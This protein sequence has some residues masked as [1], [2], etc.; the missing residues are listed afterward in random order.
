MS[1]LNHLI[2]HNYHRNNKSQHVNRQ[3]KAANSAANSA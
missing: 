2:S 1:P 3:E